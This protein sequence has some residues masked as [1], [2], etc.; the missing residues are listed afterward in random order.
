MM[1]LRRSKKRTSAA[2]PFQRSRAYRVHRP[3]RQFGMSTALYI[4]A[5]L[6]RF[7]PVMSSRSSIAGLGPHVPSDD[8]ELALSLAARLSL[9][10]CSQPTSH[11]RACAVRA[12]AS[13]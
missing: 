9:R 4:E 8:F 11:Q 7:D 3:P 2:F 12:K 5:E 6:S 1:I 10:I 13:Q